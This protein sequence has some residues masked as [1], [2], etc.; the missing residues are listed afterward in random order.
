MVEPVP[1]S[2]L[3]NGSNSRNGLMSF[4][5][6]SWRAAPS[7]RHDGESASNPRRDGHSRRRRDTT[8]SCRTGARRAGE[9]KEPFEAPDLPACAARGARR[10][11]G[12]ACLTVRASR[13][14]VVFAV[15]AVRVGR[16]I[17]ARKDL[18][19]PFATCGTAADEFPCRSGGVIVFEE[20]ATRKE[21]VV[22]LVE[23]A[24]EEVIVQDPSAPP[25]RPLT[26]TTPPPQ[27]RGSSPETGGVSQGSGTS[28]PGLK[29]KR[30]V[31]RA[32]KKAVKD[33]WGS[34]LVSRSLRELRSVGPDEL[35]RRATIDR[36]RSGWGNEGY[37]AKAEYIEEMVY[38]LKSVPG[39]ILECGSGLTTLLLGALAEGHG[40]EVWTLEN[41]LVWHA[42]VERALRKYQLG[43]VRL[44]AAPL[45][46]Y[47][48]YSWYMPT[49]ELPRRF[50]LVICDGPPES[51]P[52]GRYGLLPSMGDRMSADTVVLLDDAARE[53]EL[54]VL[55][56]WHQEGGWGAEIHG[57]GTARFA[58]V[59]CA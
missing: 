24:P 35:P 18:L 27:G 7:T 1:L 52:G 56:R 31:P 47:G 33:F 22:R 45:V 26:M 49:V 57:V 5:D 15:P 42:R 12:P 29:L 43:A 39:P 4:R 59:R 8:R 11:P 41:D 34:R 44:C 17:G 50:G 25:P 23:D 16:R 54:N 55:D 2:R 46:D 58:V 21:N 10:T 3:E 13:H 36:L 6:I 40:T 53:S 14:K 19:G 48:T 9:R 37:T 30:L 51:T 38:W 32:A 28:G 20:R